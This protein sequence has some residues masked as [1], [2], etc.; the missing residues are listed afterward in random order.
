MFK[1]TFKK[2]MKF[3]VPLSLI[4]IF[5]FSNFAPFLKINDAEAAAT[6]IFLTTGT[7]WTVPAN[8][9]S[10]NNT[11]EV[12]GGGG[13]GEVGAGSGGSANQGGGGGGGGA[14]AKISNLTLTA[15]G[16]VTIQVGAG[17][18]SAANGTDTW[19]NS[20][21]CAGA[22]TCAK[23]GS[24]GAFP[25]GGV[26]GPSGTSVGTTVF[27][28]GSGGNGQAVKSTNGGGGG[29]GAGLN[30]AGTVGA[31][32]PTATGGSGDA[33]F[34]GAGGVV[35]SGV[36][37]NGTEWS[38]SYGSGGGG[39]G[40][41]ANGIAGGAGGTYGAGGGG[42]R[43]TAGAGGAGIQGLIVITYTPAGPTVTSADVTAAGAT[44]VTGTTVANTVTSARQTDT[45]R[46]N[47][48]GF[49]ATQGASTVSI[50]G[51]ASV[52][53]GTW[54]DTVLSGIVVPA[55]AGNTGNITV[56]VGAAANL[57]FTI[58]PRLCSVDVTAS[59]A[60]TSIATGVVDARQGDT[61]TFNGDHF[62]TTQLTGLVTVLGVNVTTGLTW[63]A[64]AISGIVIPSGTT[65]TGTVGVTRDGGGVSNT[66]AFTIDPTITSVT[67]CDKSGFP[68][69]A[70]GREYNVADASCPNTLTDGAVVLTGNHF[71]TAGSVTILG[72]AST[73]SAVAAF[74]GGVAYAS[75]CTALQ[76]PTAI[77]G[78]AYTGSVVLSRTSDSKTS[79]LT[80]F[81]VLPRMTSLV[82][83][84]ASVGDAITINGDHFCQA[85]VCPT[86]PATGYNVTFTSGVNA[87]IT[88]ANWTDTGITTTVPTGTVTGNATT[89][90]NSYTSNNLVFTLASAVPNDPTNLNQWRDSALSNAIAVG[91]VASSTPIYLSMTMQVGVSGG[92]LY[93]QVE[94][95]AIGTAFACTG[96]TACLGA[97]EG[98]GAAGPGPVTGTT[99]ITTADNVYHWQA[100]VRHNKSGVDYYSNWVPFGANAETATDFQIDTT[101]PAVSSVSSGTPGTNGATITWSTSLEAGTSRVEYNKT[102]TFTGGYD[103]AGTTECT[104]LA[105]TAPLVNSHS[106]ALSNLSSGTTYYYRV[107]S[108]DAA[109]N[110]T[111]SIN[112][113]FAT[114][115]V[116]QPAKTTQF[117]IMGKTA[118]I[119][120]TAPLSQSF[121]IVMPETAT[122]TKSIFVEIRGIY[123]AAATTPTLTVQ[124]NSEASKVY[125]LPTVASTSHLKILHSV[126]AVSVSPGT[127]TLTITPDSNTTVYITSA[128]V[129]VSYAYTP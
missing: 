104:A 37:G 73:Q 36:G 96:T 116:T 47:G 99:T 101:P 45:I 69:G 128:D 123:V 68:T 119:T 100:R 76:V 8:W 31:A 49:G 26:G 19:F 74:C 78:N 33:G 97:T 6:V 43:G 58:L 107:R 2:S 117:H 125:T 95:Q 15:N 87:T 129:Y 5:V 14:Y 32:S 93:P 65:D 66:K 30:G 103:C 108:K 56:T 24:T 85:G 1:K 40:A 86:L 115:S 23:A 102:G 29:G 9:N 17:G 3:A 110:E 126:L 60:G 7:S 11:I 112:Y 75:T 84:S 120:S 61:V 80:G 10:A 4:A 114:Q 12:I 51:S 27:S 67:D 20:S 77:A 54:S 106:V 46:I 21:T 44:C 28:G 39:G 16:S 25:T 18:A 88:S 118:S 83:S 70:F 127:N 71:G 59:S 91:G 82:P 38:A 72:S 42:G 124:V 62:N 121:T 98:V 48:T 109:G 89:T 111:I 41:N 94:Y 57:A 90:S 52:T 55:D 34:G 64:T 92:T 81:R 13:G 50:N 105:D 35:G 79:S 53:V 122:S 22:S 63:S 113:T